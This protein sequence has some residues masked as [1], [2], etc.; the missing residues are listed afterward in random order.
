VRKLFDA[1]KESAPTPAVDALVYPEY[2]PADP[3][4]F[5]G[6]DEARDE[7]RLSRMILPNPSAPKGLR[8]SRKNTSEKIPS[9]VLKFADY[10]VAAD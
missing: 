3:D 2:V 6:F 10:V 4:P 9:S 7:H 8:G 5:E 1:V